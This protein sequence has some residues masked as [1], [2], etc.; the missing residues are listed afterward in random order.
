MSGRCADGF[1]RLWVCHEARV[2][3]T[4]H[5]LV[6]LADEAAPGVWLHSLGT[7]VRP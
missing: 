1:Y 6:V 7:G 3:A 5:R 2:Q 4:S